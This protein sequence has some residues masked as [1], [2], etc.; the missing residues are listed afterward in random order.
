MI[1]YLAGSFPH[2]Y[3]ISKEKELMK[4]I[5]KKHEY[6]RLVSFFYPKTCDTVLT[7]RG[8]R[9][10]IEPVLSEKGKGKT[11]KDF[12][13]TK[14]NTLIIAERLK[15]RF[16]WILDF[17]WAGDITFKEGRRKTDVQAAAER[18]EEV[19]FGL[20]MV[21]TYLDEKKKKRETQIIMRHKDKPF[22]SINLKS[23]VKNPQRSDLVKQM[24]GVWILLSSGGTIEKPKA[25]VL[26]TL[27]EYKEECLVNAEAKGQAGRFALQF[28]K[29]A[30]FT[31]CSTNIFGEDAEAKLFEK[32]RKVS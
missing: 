12:E 21:M 11:A 32:I 31:L 13:K 15:K 27:G 30:K 14:A 23:W 3:S 10:G 5:E 29:W 28:A 7:L 8:E 2:L 1:L 26:T 9:M 19:S 17:R 25:I 24:K 4:S 16:D 22:Y 6:H 20:N 18:G